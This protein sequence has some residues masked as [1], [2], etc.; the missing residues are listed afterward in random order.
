MPTEADPI[1]STWYQNYGKGQ[2]FAVIG[3]DNTRGLVEIQLFDGTVDELDLETW[4][5]LELA[6][7]AAPEDWTGPMDDIERD[8]L[9]Y[10]DTGMQ[11][12]DWR[13]SR[14]EITRTREMWE[15]DDEPLDFLAG[16]RSQEDQWDDGEDE[17]L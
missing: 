3:I 16:D 11:S 1:V 8:D 14:A 15:E 10:T 5:E 12:E 6:P 17:P 2:K 9:G 7:I 4:Y 13:A